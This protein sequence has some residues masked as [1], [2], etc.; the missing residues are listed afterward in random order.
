[1]PSTFSPNLRLEL[2]G[3]GEAAGLWGV[4]TNN[5]LG[6]LLEQAISGATTLNVTSGNITLT[7]LNG[8]VDE[9]RSAV[10]QVT[11][12][13]G[14]TRVLT[15][16]NVQK[17]YTVRNSSDAAVDIKTAS[18]VAY[19]IPA[20]ATA[21]IYCDGSNNVTGRTIT[22]GAEAILSNPTP[23]NSPA[24][25][26]VPTAPTAA[27]GTNTTQIA[28][29]AFVN[30]EIASDT[31]NLA[32]LNSPSLTGTPTAPTA[33]VGTNTTQLATTQF[34]NAEIA[35]DAPTKTGGGASG[36]WGINITGNA[37]TA[38]NATNATNA[39]NLNGAFKCRAWAN[40]NGFSGQASIRASGGVSSVTYLSEGYYSVNFSTPMA[41]SN[42]ACVTGVDLNTTPN[43]GV[44]SV[45]FR[46]PGNVGIFT[47]DAWRNA[48]YLTDPTDFLYIGIAVFR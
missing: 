10:L 40:I 28:T 20:A 37:A 41:D 25:T 7:A 4:L 17:V 24:F 46:N 29:T 22:D 8:V 27:Q 18:G 32:P 38:T 15:I 13:P 47:G 43:I 16:P 9:A 31:A 14:T 44:A 39:E 6:D 21:Y 2:I 23:Y 48:S 3:T 19:S 33:A 35:N 12:T 11:G 26:G 42:Y 45:L 5:N 30:A 1:M 34:V 36:T